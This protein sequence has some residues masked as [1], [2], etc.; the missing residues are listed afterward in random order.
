[1]SP[2]LCRDL[3]RLDASALPDGEAAMQAW[4]DGGQ[5]P[6]DATGKGRVANFQERGAHW[7]AGPVPSLW[8]LWVRLAAEKGVKIAEEE[9]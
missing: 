8:D 2:D 5:C 7:S 1:M 6:L 9:G 4:A 3:M